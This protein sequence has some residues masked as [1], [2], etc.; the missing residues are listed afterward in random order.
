MDAEAIP[1][2][3]E[4]E[5]LGKA[6]CLMKKTVTLKHNN[7]S[8]QVL[9]YAVCVYHADSL[10]HANFVHTCKRCPNIEW[11]GCNEHSTYSMHPSL[12]SSPGVHMPI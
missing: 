7:V 9:R 8:H 3:D 1:V 5:S 6:L 12:L 2:G 4:R 11:M 10:R